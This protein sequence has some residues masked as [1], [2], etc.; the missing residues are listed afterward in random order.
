MV[1]GF[2][3]S[4]YTIKVYTT[5]YTNIDANFAKSCLATV[6]INDHIDPYGNC[7]IN[8]ISLEDLGCEI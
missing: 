3:K 8:E 1:F 2:F 4:F 6:K 7:N 5:I